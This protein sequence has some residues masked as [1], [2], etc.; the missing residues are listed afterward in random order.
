MG[1]VHGYH[2][3]KDG[4]GWGDRSIPDGL[5]F[6]AACI[7]RARAGRGSMATRCGLLVRRCSSR[8]PSAPCRRKTNPRIHPDIAAYAAAAREETV[9]SLVAEAKQAA[10]AIQK[11]IVIDDLRPGDHGSRPWLLFR[12]PAMARWSAPMTWSRRWCASTIAAARRVRRS[13]SP[14]RRG[15]SRFR[16]RNRG[17]A[18]L[19]VRAEA[20]VRSGADSL[21]FYNYGLI[22]AA[23]L[24][25]IGAASQAARTTGK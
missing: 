4:V 21:N 2:H 9:T 19:A 5:C 16:S 22:P 17:A 20:A 23:R 1:F 6:C 18:D 25:W 24:D 15:V 11:S 10:T 13:R 8:R 7:A 12:T 14:S 3:E